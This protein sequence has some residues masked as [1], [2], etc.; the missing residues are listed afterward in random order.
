MNRKENGRDNAPAKSFFNRLKHER[1][2][3]TR[4]GARAKAQAK[5]FQPYRAVL[6]PQAL[7]FYAAM[8]RLGNI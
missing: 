4:H 2:H 3:G 5:R 6:Q 1:T 7:S 8:P